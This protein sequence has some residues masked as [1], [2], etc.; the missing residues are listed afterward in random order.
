MN[1]LLKIFKA[2]SDETR[3]KII[4]SLSKSE[5]CVNELAETIGTTQPNASF[6]LGI[7]LEAGLITGRQS[8]K[9]IFYSLKTSDLF[10]RLLLLGIAERLKSTNFNEE[11]FNSNNRCGLKPKLCKRRAFFNKENNM[12]NESGR[13]L[14]AGGFCVCPSCGEKIPHKS[15]MPCKNEVC[16]KCGKRMVRE[17][18]YHYRL[19][20][21]REEKDEDTNGNK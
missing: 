9:N 1:E 8:G 16:P 12:N 20:K 15:G 17:G 4:D 21:E 6:H 14:G 18:G 7:L 19:I 13:G 10:I 5:L 11:I 3:L 2:L